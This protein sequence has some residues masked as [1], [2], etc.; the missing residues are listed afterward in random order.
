[1]IPVNTAPEPQV[2]KDAAEEQPVISFTR[3]IE[4]TPSA[5][6]FSGWGPKVVSMSGM[7]A[8]FN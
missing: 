1:M 4:S 6:S 3:V 8:R 7:I 2:K 5:A